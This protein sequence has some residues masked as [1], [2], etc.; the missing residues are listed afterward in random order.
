MASTFSTYLH[1]ETPKHLKLLAKWG[2]VSKS[3]KFDNN[4][5]VNDLGTAFTHSFYLAIGHLARSSIEIV[6]TER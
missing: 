4:I 6:S 2:H 1:T 5:N 3:K